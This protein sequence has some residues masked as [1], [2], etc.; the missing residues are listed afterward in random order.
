MLEK[1][2]LY[3]LY[4]TIVLGFYLFIN[5]EVLLW[6][7]INPDGLWGIL[8]FSSAS[9][10]LFVALFVLID[11]YYV[12]KMNRKTGSLGLG[13]A[14]GLIL[15]SLLGFVFYYGP[16]IMISKFMN[17]RYRY[18]KQSEEYFSEGRYND[19]VEYAEK[20]YEK[21]IDREEPSPLLL[22]PYLYYHSDIY[23]YSIKTEEYA[24]IVN[25]GYCLRAQGI[26]LKESEELFKKSLF[27]A[28]KYLNGDSEFIVF[29]WIE[30]TK[31]Y[32]ALGETKKSEDSFNKLLDLTNNL[33]KEDVIYVIYALFNYA[34]YYE[35]HGNIEEALKLRDKALGV[36]DKSN[37][38]KESI[39]YLRILL[40]VINDN[41]ST[42]NF[43]DARDLFNVAK[44][45]AED[46]D[47][48]NVYVDY[49]FTKTNILSVE[50]K[51]ATACD[52]SENNLWGKLLSLFVEPDHC[53]EYLF[54]QMEKTLFQ[55]LDEIEDRQGKDHLN[56]ASGLNIIGLFYYQSGADSLASLYFNKALLSSEP[57]KDK[58]QDIYYSILLNLAFSDYN[59][60]KTSE[61]LTKLRLAVNNML[62]RTNK[63]FL[64][65]TEE[66]KESYMF[67][68]SNKMSL[69][70][71]IYRYED[72]SLTNCLL[73]NN[74]LAS[75]SI[76]LQ[77][78]Q[79]LKRAIIE[80]NDSAIA[81]KYFSLMR[82]KTELNNLLLSNI[83]VAV[84]ERYKDSV[85]IAEKEI[86]RA[87]RDKGYL[88]SFSVNSITWEDIKNV[89]EEDEVIVEFIKTPFLPNKKDSIIYSALII[90]KQSEYPKLINLTTEKDI[91]DILNIPGGIIERVN[92]IYSNDTL[93][94][95]IWKPLQN[96]ISGFNKV[97][98][99]LSGVLY[100][101]SL[102]GLL[103][104]DNQEVIVMSSSRNLIFRKSV[105]QA[106]YSKYVLYGDIDY[107]IPPD[108]N[109][110]SKLL[111]GNSI[112]IEIKRAGFDP[113][114]YTKK[115]IS[116]IDSILKNNNYETIVY[117]GQ[118]A[119]EASFKQLSNKKFQIIHIATHGFYYPPRQS[120]RANELYSDRNAQMAVKDNP[121]LRTGLLM[122][123]ALSVHKDD[124][125]DGILTA[126]EISKMDLSDVDMVVLSACETGLGDIKGEE[127]VF[128]LQRGFKNAGVKNIIM[129]LWSVP[130]MQTSKLMEKFYEYY[131]NGY[132]KHIALKKSQLFIKQKYPN[133]FYW[134]A[135][136]LVE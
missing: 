10:F 90:N 33:N 93:Y 87:I 100:K 128:G 47:D 15:L 129:S 42:G 21:V 91:S 130:D 81:T 23:L 105:E 103:H 80:N 120:F 22:I 35:S 75:K 5:L 28:E 32:L 43:T 58:N 37:R 104:D 121:L 51:N 40:R 82:R 135:F 48:K 99:S 118:A 109:D 126:F 64:F 69:V 38:N 117:S 113:L 73:F 59:T 14:I 110:T 74:V 98:V 71:S 77:S 88:E 114:P 67:T 46:F 95:L 4:F 83:D 107:G 112:E 62:D 56:Y 55:L 65:Y 94:D 122:S 36:Y 70:N 72:D 20:V 13:G 34:F 52:P 25:Y 133:P 19:A 16:A 106:N 108:K 79:Y 132:P 84:G 54:G 8:W 102:S 131:V 97:Y 6:D 101:I 125:N 18:I 127:G 115:E 1:I 39:I 29:P 53:K 30:L 86:L 41:I 96:H 12:I 89:L 44:G 119:S 57:D 3:F 2:K 123:N 134:A 7:I 61:S 9:T 136:V 31:I 116:S 68:A 60:G 49:L 66:E 124:D 85:R 78:N 26:K 76:A 11:V 63:N 17:D 92:G 27:I 111:T 45:F 50:L 24:A